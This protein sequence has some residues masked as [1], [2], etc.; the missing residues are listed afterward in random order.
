LVNTSK[1]LLT[2]KAQL[3][4][5]RIGAVAHAYPSSGN[6]LLCR[7]KRLTILSEF[8]EIVKSSGLMSSHSLDKFGPH[9]HTSGDKSCVDS[10]FSPCDST[11]RNWR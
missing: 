4:I 2:V 8:H 5:T 7:N 1:D 10:L 9:W 11:L 3:Y 6:H